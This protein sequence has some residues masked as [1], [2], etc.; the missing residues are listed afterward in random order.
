MNTKRKREDMEIVWQ[1]PAN[2][3]ERHD[4]I[5]RNGKFFLSSI[6]VLSALY[7]LCNKLLFFFCFTCAG[8]RYVKPYYFEF[9]SHVQL[10]LSLTDWFCHFLNEFVKTLTKSCIWIQIDFSGEESLGWEDNCWSLLW[11]IQR[12][13]SWLLCM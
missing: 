4:Y 1:T 13:T 10:L 7:I 12:K 5:F 3:P 8:I 6:S 11:W 2:P 9:I